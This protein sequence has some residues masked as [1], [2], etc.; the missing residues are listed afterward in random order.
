MSGNRTTN[1]VT[2]IWLDCTICHK[3]HSNAEPPETYAYSLCNRLAF[4]ALQVD[5]CILP[6]WR[7]PSWVFHSQFSRTVYI[8][9]SSIALLNLKNICLAVGILL[10][11]CIQTETCVF[12][13]DGTILDFLFPVEYF[14]KSHCIAGFFHTTS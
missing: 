12:P 13:V 6:A 4:V 3:S 1:L 14:H 8:L 11:P 10:K 5:T 2:L 9:T 7:L